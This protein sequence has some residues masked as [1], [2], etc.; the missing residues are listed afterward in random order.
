MYG[1]AHGSVAACNTSNVLAGAPTKQN[2]TNKTQ[3]AR[4]ASTTF[5]LREVEP[6][7]TPGSQT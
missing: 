1:L 3:H 7:A 4:N 5:Q 6:A 2:K